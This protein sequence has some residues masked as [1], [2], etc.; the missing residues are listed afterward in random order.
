MNATGVVYTT[1]SVQRRLTMPSRTLFRVYYILTSVG[2]RS[3]RSIE[4]AVVGQNGG[5]ADEDTPLFV[6]CSQNVRI[7]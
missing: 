2:I 1:R 5:R 7:L 6:C 3:V 4:M